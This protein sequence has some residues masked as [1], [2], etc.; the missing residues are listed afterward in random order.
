MFILLCNG[1]LIDPFNNKVIENGGILYNEDG[2]ILGIDTTDNLRK[3][4]FELT[5][6]EKKLDLKIVDVKGKTI[7]PGIVCAHHHFYSS[8]ARGLGIKN[9][10]PKNFVDILNQLWWRLDN[11]LSKEEIYYSAVVALIDCLRHGV[12]TVIDHHESQNFQLGSLEQIFHAVEF[13]GLRASL[14]LGVSDRFGKGEDGIKENEN[15]LNKINSLKFEEKNKTVD[16]TTKISSS[17]INAMVGLHASFTVEDKTLEKIS[18]LK[19]KY[20]VGIHTHCAEDLFDEE[21]CVKKYGIRVV[22]RFKKFNLLGPKTI[23]AHCVHINEKEME[24]ISETETNVVVNPESNMNNAVGCADVLKMLSYEI[25]VGLGTD[26]MSSDMLS[27]ARSLFLI[28]RHVK[29]DSTVG[30]VESVDMLFKNNLKIVENIFGKE[31]NKF[32]V[33]QCLDAVVFNYIPPTPITDKNFYGHLLF[34]ILY[35]SVDTVI[36]NGKTLLK[37]GCI[38][39]FS[40]KDVLKEAR[41]VA[42]KF[43]EKF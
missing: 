6:I 24:I 21:D 2:I 5:E 31:Y 11:Q 8:F 17:L 32:K 12:T 26:A 36:V 13:V 35:S 20:N 39:H 15:F 14:C 16:N 30:F 28:Q 3:K 34:G 42:E 4:A 27:T 38:E 22:E 43:W 23:L 18:Q 9:Y 10:N 41:K 25:N 40:E 1:I 37:D 29:Q 33:G 19:E 7:L